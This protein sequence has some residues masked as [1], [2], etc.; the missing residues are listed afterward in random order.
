ME[1]QDGIPEDAVEVVRYGLMEL[2][3]F[4]RTC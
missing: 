4:I 3:G 2:G 1:E